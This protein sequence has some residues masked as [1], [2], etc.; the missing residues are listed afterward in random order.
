MSV[1]KNS[2]WDSMKK[3]GGIV[4][5]EKQISKRKVLGLLVEFGGIFQIGF[6]IMLWWKPYGFGFRTVVTVPLISI[7]IRMDDNRT[8]YPDAPISKNNISDLGNSQSDVASP[9]TKVGSN[10]ICDGLSAGRLD[11]KFRPGADERFK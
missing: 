4:N 2:S 9:S 3:L 1:V 7:E 10:N 11:G 5:F 6:S 8:W